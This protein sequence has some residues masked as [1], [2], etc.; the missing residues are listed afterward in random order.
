MTIEK[1][2]LSR[3]RGYDSPALYRQDTILRIRQLEKEIQESFKKID[4][5]QREMGA[6]NFSLFAN[7]QR[8][9]LHKAEN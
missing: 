7:R 4:I 6:A 3:F 1:T 5:L 8:A 9:Y 2:P